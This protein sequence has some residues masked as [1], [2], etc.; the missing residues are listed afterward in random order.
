MAE[1][2]EKIEQVKKLS[3]SVASFQRVIQEEDASRLVADKQRFDT[4]MAQTDPVS[5]SHKIEAD[6]PIKIRPTIMDE[7]AGIN[8]RMDYNSKM[9]AH[10]LVAQTEEAIKKI[11]GLKTTLSQPNIEIP[12]SAQYLLKDKLANIND[13]LKVAFQKAGL[14]YVPPTGVGEVNPVKRFL[15]MLA[16]GQNQLESLTAHVD[17]LARSKTEMGAAD[18]LALQLKVNNIQQELE[19]FTALLSKSLESTKTLMNVQV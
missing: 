5:K 13:S 7:A 19:F 15:D 12:G 1:P 18:M 17:G 11:D 10:D 2:I 6:D 4:A 14:E 8:K 9:S 16:H 3:K